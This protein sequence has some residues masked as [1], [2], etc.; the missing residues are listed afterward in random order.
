MAEITSHP[1]L[2]PVFKWLQQTSGLD[3]NEMLRTFNC[4]IGM[5]L[6][7][8]SEN[9]NAVKEILASC[10]ETEV[11]DLGTITKGDRK[12]VMKIQLQ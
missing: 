11:Y 1:P 7:I 9:I 8:S 2:P 4:G 5:V 3:D 10:D 12:V 6:I